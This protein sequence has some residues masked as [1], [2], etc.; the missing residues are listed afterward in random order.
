MAIDSPKP[1]SNAGFHCVLCNKLAGTVELLPAGHPD[2]LSK[3]QATIFLRDFIGTEKVLVSAAGSPAVQAAL[4]QADAAAL[5]EADHLWAPFYCPTCKCVYCLEHWVV[6]PQY[7][8]GYFDCSYG[9]C[10]EGHRRMTE[11]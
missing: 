8:E 7:D 11:D 10:P 3:N 5:Y 4:D 9:T 1:L 6:I 2:G